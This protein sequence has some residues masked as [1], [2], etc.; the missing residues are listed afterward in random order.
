M[1]TDE[2][3]EPRMATPSAPPSS[4]VVSFMAEPTPALPRGTDD[5]I[6]VVSGVMVVA[7]PAASGM[8]DR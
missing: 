3:T 8:I 5:M 2:T 4:R 1:Y 7:M 6:S